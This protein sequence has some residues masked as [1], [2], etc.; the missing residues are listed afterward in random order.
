MG[1]VL[2]ANTLRWETILLV[3]SLVVANVSMFSMWSLGDYQV[4]FYKSARYLL[5]GDNIYT[6]PYPHPF[7][8][9]EYPP[10]NPIWAIHTIVPISVFPL[11]LAGSLRYFIDLL[12]IP[13]VIY[14][15]ARMVNLNTRWG[16]LFVAT[17][18]WHY[19][20]LYSGQ[21]TV[22]VF[23][24][25]LLCYYGIH[26]RNV[27]LV[28]I[29]VW[30]AMIKV[31]LALLIILA[32]LWLAWRNGIFSRTVAWLV[33]LV[34]LSSLA[35]PLWLYDLLMLYYD[36][37]Q[38]PRLVDSLLLLPAYPWAQL[39]LLAMGIL[40]ASWYLMRDRVSKPEPWFWA[41][42][43]TIGLVS[44]LHTF[45][46]DWLVLGLPM[47]WL[48]RDRVKRIWWLAMLYVYPLIWMMVLLARGL[49]I[50]F[51]FFTPGA[52]MMSAVWGVLAPGF[53]GLAL[54][55]QAR[56]MLSVYIAL[57]GMMMVLVFVQPALSPAFIPG[58]VLLAMVVAI[59]RQGVWDKAVYAKEMGRQR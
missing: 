5:R 57:I 11:N 45:T 32:T 54:N 21:W 51:A 20:T 16:I 9:R 43:I 30:L 25:M 8:G 12:M 6:S 38:N 24:G 15:C 2:V 19:I 47:A 3:L 33:V 34:T 55:W 41:L 7:I 22:L 58:M 29:G 50:H 27:P 23:L 17:A 37:L 4:S 26:R 49:S 31:N 1:K 13:F 46:Y 42:L 39:I 48:L 59:L 44:A 10:F 52:F 14:L 56:V 28:V 36:R 40:F 18:P 35:Q 53:V